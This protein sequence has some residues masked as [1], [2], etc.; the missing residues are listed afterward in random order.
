MVVKSG[1]VVACRVVVP[2][3]C[4]VEGHLGEDVVADVRVGDVVEGV[5]QQPP[6][7]TVHRAQRAAEPAPLLP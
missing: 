6:E 4:V 1:R 5:V 2:D 3:L 7:R